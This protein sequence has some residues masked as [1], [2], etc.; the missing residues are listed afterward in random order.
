MCTQFGHPSLYTFVNSFRPVFRVFLCRTR[1][2][3]TKRRNVHG[4]RPVG[5]KERLLLHRTQLQRPGRQAGA[6]MAGHRAAGEG[7]QE[8]GGRTVAAGP[9]G[10]HSAG[11]EPVGRLEP[12][13]AVQR[14]YALLA[15]DH[16]L[17]GAAHHLVVLLLQRE[18]PHR[19]LLRA[20]RHHA[21]RAAGAA[22][23]KFLSPRAENT[24]IHQCAAA[25]RQSPQGAEAGGETGPHP[26][27]SG[28]QG[29]AAQTGTVHGRLLHRRGDGAVV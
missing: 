8:K 10:L 22:H 26:R 21:G 17:L 24:E 11:A 14:L 20:H 28:G 5:R 16:P 9:P 19:A 2:T 25:A 27:Q 18:G 13:Y 12:G 1:R 3:P 4:S 23:P 29:G 7:Q 15:G 6:E